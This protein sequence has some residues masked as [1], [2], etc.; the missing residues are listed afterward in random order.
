MMGITRQTCVLAYNF[1]DGF[2]NYVLP[3]SSALMGVLGAAN[4]PYGSWMKFMGKIFC[5]WVLL[6]CVLTSAAQ[7]IQLGPH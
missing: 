2:S 4:V 3:T 6:S 7:Y 1:G 5:V